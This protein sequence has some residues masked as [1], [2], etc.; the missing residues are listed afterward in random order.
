HHDAHDH[1]PD[2]AERGRTHRVRR[3][4][5]RAVAPEQGRDRPGAPGQ[6]PRSGPVGAPESRG[7][8][9]LLQPG[10]RH[11]GRAHPAAARVHAAVGQGRRPRAG[12]RRRHAAAPDHRPRPDQQPR[13]GHSRRADHRPRPAGPGN[14]LEAP[15]RSQA[16]GQ[17]AA[18]HHPLHGR[19]AAPVRRHRD[20]RS[21]PRSRSRPAGRA[22]RPAR[23]GPRIGAAKARAAAPGERPLGARGH[24]RCGPVLRRGAARAD[25]RIARGRRLLAPPGEPRGRVPAAHRPPAARELMIEAQAI[26]THALAVC[27]RQY[28]VWRKIIWASLTANV[29]N[30]LRFLCAFGSGLGAV[31]DRMAGLDYLAF[32]VPG[33]MAYSAMFAAS[34]ETT[35]GAYSRF[36][37]QK[38]WDA[39]LATPVSLVELLLGETAW[40]AC[41]AMISA[42]CVLLV[43]A[44]WGGVGSAFGALLSLPLILLG[45]VGFATCGLV[46]TAYAKSWEFFSYFFTFWV[47]PMFIFSGVFFSVDRFPDYVEPIAWILPMTHL[48]EVVRPLV[49]G[50]DLAPLAALGHILYLTAL[51]VAAF[52]IA[53]RRFK[54]RLFD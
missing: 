10:P 8:R 30:P 11:P 28:L 31:V 4:R 1:G 24:R 29:V 47:T 16:R 17:D 27:R 48:I 44:L 39:T 9:Q 6:Q 18:A 13:P 41:K 32:L 22:D 3:A 38:T 50:Q 14:D 42:L 35:I 40:A 34:F 53:Y 5:G 52:I 2:H 51:A 36:D 25:R 20:H 33:L 54:S 45:S 21:R 7:V 37:F 26:A 23:Q 49:T 12:A 46:A 15:A 19:G 43:G